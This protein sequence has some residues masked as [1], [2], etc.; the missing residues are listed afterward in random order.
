VFLVALV[1]NVKFFKF[2]EQRR[3]ERNEEKRR[4][5][6]ELDRMEADVGLRTEQEVSRDKQLWEKRYGN[7]ADSESALVS[8][9][10]LRKDSVRD[11]EKSLSGDD[12]LEMSDMKEASERRD[13][14]TAMTI[15]MST[16]EQPGEQKKRLKRIIINEQPPS[17]SIIP[18]P[19]AVHK[20]IDPADVPQPALSRRSSRASKASKVAESEREKSIKRFGRGADLE[21]DEQP[22]SETGEMES[23]EES[24]SE[25]G[26]ES[27]AFD[28]DE[29]SQRGF[30]SRPQSM[31]SMLSALVFTENDGAAD[32]TENRNSIISVKAKASHAQAPA[33]MDTVERPQ[34][35]EKV[36]VQDEAPVPETV[37]HVQETA[38]QD[39]REHQQASP[40]TNDDS[41]GSKTGKEHLVEPSNDAAASSSGHGETESYHA[42]E[43]TTVA[44]SEVPGDEDMMSTDGASTSGLTS[45]TSVRRREAAKLNRL[46]LAQL[47]GQSSGRLM[48]AYKQ[49]KIFEWAKESTLAELPADSEPESPPSPGMQYRTVEPDTGIQ[50]EIQFIEVEEDP[51]PPAPEKTA[52]FVQSPASE[53]T[54]TFVQPPESIT[55]QSATE[56]ISPTSLTMDQSAFSRTVSNASPSLSRQS[57]S[58]SIRPKPTRNFSSPAFGQSTLHDYPIKEEPENEAAPS[59]FPS[60]ISTLLEKREQFL[61]NRVSNVN[62]NAIPISAFSQNQSANIRASMA[63]ASS[64][65]LDD[66]DNVPLS[67]RKA[68]LH[69]KKASQSDQPLFPLQPQRSMSYGSVNGLNRDSAISLAGP[70]AGLADYRISQQSLN[71]GV[72]TFDSHQPSHG[73]DKQTPEQRAARLASW[74]VGLQN[75]PR[76]VQQVTM[77]LGDS[78]REQMMKDM[79]SQNFQQQQQTVEKERLDLLM[80]QTLRAPDAMVL[81]S[82]RLSA[83]QAQ[84]KLG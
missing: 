23:E 5:Q 15:A 25:R 14:G 82:R 74:R 69:T 31:Q 81:H 4:K 75:D 65:S 49:H 64:Q 22:L 19:F 28:I 8:T 66:A 21:E 39:N 79:R 57:S 68:M 58:A 3:L 29:F 72:A 33:F 83:M 32:G 70:A 45:K 71:K 46:S 60:N 36:T 59:P 2:L 42:P 24:G 18:L 11:G 7:G 47:G 63:S 9:D 80:D 50:P 27:S 77:A 54:A 40:P 62:F 55:S 73:E 17:P 13:S 84:A 6:E 12:S 56:S 51:E 37:E 10:S 41:E 16:E 67:V 26:Y 20:T 76:H 1:V 78:R 38:V 52:P 48:K 34:V 30:A 43:S 61:R 35:P 44:R 53:K